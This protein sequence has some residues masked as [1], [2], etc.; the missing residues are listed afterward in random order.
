MADPRTFGRCFLLLDNLPNSISV[1]SLT[2]HVPFASLDGNP[3][4]S[5]DNFS[6]G[7]W[8]LHPITSHFTHHNVG[9]SN[10]VLAHMVRSRVL[11]TSLVLRERATRNS[12]SRRGQFS[13]TN[14]VPISNTSAFFPASQLSSLPQHNHY[15]MIT[16]FHDHFLP[17]SPSFTITS[18]H[19]HF[20]SSNKSEDLII[21]I[22]KLLDCDGTDTSKDGSHQ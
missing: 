15:L 4:W 5:I 17:W 22:A 14:I 2:L 6:A 12:S 10:S 16:S 7:L 19:D 18:F 3:T 8:L 1:Q 13:F 21:T 20:F 9:W 11:S